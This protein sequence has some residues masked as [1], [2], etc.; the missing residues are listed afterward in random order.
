MGGN[1]LFRSYDRGDHWDA[2]SP[3]LSTN[4]ADKQHPGKDSPTPDINSGAEQHCSIVT[5]APPGSGKTQCNVFPNLLTWNGPAVVLDIS[6][7]GAQAY[8]G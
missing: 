3:D 6:K 2:I 8:G 7:A 4:D 5:I 1:K